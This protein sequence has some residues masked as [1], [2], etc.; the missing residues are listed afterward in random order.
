M[1]FYM[2]NKIPNKRKEDPNMK[3]ILALLLA[4]MMLL[5][6]V[7]L[8]EAVPSISAEAIEVP[9]VKIGQA[10]FAAHG[11]K[12]FAVITVAMIDDMIVAAYIE[13]FQFMAD[14]SIGVPNSDADFGT[15][16]PEGKVLAS[17]RQNSETYSASM[18]NAGSTVAL[19]DNYKAIEAYVVG[20]TIAELEADLAGKTAE[21]AVDAVSGATLVD[22]LGY[23]Q[24]ILAA[25]KA[26]E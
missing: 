19:I 1:L 14:T 3:K 9:E 23:L 13:E 12:C 2:R 5:P 16:F 4:L 7:A 15:S 26:A 22:T 21:T 18:A 17:K 6:V 20:M 8:G 24:G 25:A 10:L 11:T